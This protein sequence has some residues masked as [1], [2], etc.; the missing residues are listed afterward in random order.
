MVKTKI[1]LIQLPEIKTLG[2][3]ESFIRAIDRPGKSP[4]AQATLMTKMLQ[5]GLSG[6]TA[7]TFWYIIDG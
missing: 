1:N 3:Y 4:K 7:E 6:K 5:E 2:E